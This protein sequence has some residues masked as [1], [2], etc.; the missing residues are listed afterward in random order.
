ME[1]KGAKMQTLAHSVAARNSSPLI[2]YRLYCVA[3]LGY[4]TVKVT[5]F[6]L[7]PLH[8]LLWQSVQIPSSHPCRK[9]VLRR[10]TACSFDIGSTQAI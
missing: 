7:E 9:G 4:G 8:C 10:T 2:A 5:R 3:Y 6:D 1:Y